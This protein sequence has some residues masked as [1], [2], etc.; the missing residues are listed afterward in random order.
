MNILGLNTGWTDGMIGILMR[1]ILHT[2]IHTHT[3]RNRSLEV[4]DGEPGAVP[5]LNLVSINVSCPGVGL[6]DGGVGIRMRPED[7][8]QHDT[9][10]FVDGMESGGWR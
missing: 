5:V 1:Y 9:D 2:V 6:Y 10:V 3:T 4:E 8:I 7:G